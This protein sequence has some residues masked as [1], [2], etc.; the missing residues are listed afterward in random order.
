M[1]T[2]LHNHLSR[3]TVMYIRE[4]VPSRSSQPG[5]KGLGAF[6]HRDKSERI[7]VQID[8]L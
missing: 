5:A 1:I 7:T 4:R 3:T 2:A 8:Q 6:R